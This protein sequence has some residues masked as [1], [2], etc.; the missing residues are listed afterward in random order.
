[1]RLFYSSVTLFSNCSLQEFPTCADM[2]ELCQLHLL[3][4]I[5]FFASS[6]SDL[7]CRS[8]S[9]NLLLLFFNLRPIA[10]PHISFHPSYFMCCATR[11]FLPPGFCGTLV[12]KS[13][14]TLVDSQYCEPSSRLAVISQV[15]FKTSFPPSFRYWPD[16]VVVYFPPYNKREERL[17]RFLLN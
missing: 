17:C 7:L 3:Y 6:K 8:L 9:P 15:V 16:Q 1:M 12:K 10:R 4:A 5:D 11:D 2:L 14:L 13:W